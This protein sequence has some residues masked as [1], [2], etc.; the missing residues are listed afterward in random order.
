MMQ[1]ALHAGPNF[2]LLNLHD[3][4]VSPRTVTLRHLMIKNLILDWSGT[5]ANDLPAVLQG[6]NR[7][8]KLFRRPQLTEAEFRERF[9]LPY[10]EFYREVLPGVPLEKLKALY[11]RFFHNAL[12]MIPLIDHAR[13]FLEYAAAEKKRM[14]L[15]SS[16]PLDHVEEQARHLGVWH[17]FEHAACG[18]VDKREH[19]AALMLDRGFEPHH[20][21]FVGDMRHDIE[22]GKAARVLTIATC[23]GYES[24]AKLQ[25][26][27]P[28]HLIANLS[29]L[30]ALLAAF[31][32]GV[33]G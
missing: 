8:L 16:A 32:A 24:V 31:G 12:S 7:M 22:A 3:L 5:L 14:V 10:T 9:R 15:F 23:T 19:I 6:L 18:V 13:E 11:L 30:P 20:T 27:E 29:E 2:A 25:S 28:D 21:A 33:H 17:F 4:D 26:A 1:E